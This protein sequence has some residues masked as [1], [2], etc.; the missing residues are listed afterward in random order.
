MY[1]PKK[2]FLTKG[3]GVHKEKLAS[4]EAALRDA[5]IASLNIVNVSSIFPPQAKLISQ[6][7]G[8]KLVKPGAITHVVLSKLSTNEPYRHVVASVGIAIPRD[9][10]NYGYLSE[11][12]AYGQKA[13]IAGEYAEDLAAQML[14]TILG[15]SFNPEASWD[16]QREIWR[17]SGKIYQTTH[18]VQEAEGDPRGYWTTVLAAAVLLP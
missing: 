10:N 7:E 5:R 17:I 8:L 9:P 16:E 11:H 15:V 14:A 18:I 2:I 3:Q 1:V 4:F 12:H 13:E 6:A